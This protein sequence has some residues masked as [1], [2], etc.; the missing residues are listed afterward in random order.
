MIKQFT[1]LI[2]ITF[3]ANAYSYFNNIPVGARATGMAGVFTSIP[4]DVSLVYYNPAGLEFINQKELMTDYS[5]MYSGLTDNSNITNKFIGLNFY[6]AQGFGSAAAGF[7]NTGLDGYVQYS[8]FILSY[9]KKIKRVSIG[10]NTK[11]ISENYSMNNYTSDDPVFSNGTVSS[12]Q[13]YS[14]D[15]SGL[16]NIA[17]RIYAGIMIADITQPVMQFKQYNSV[18]PDIDKVPLGIRAGISFVDSLIT[19]AIDFESVQDS[20]KIYS[21]FEKWF[22]KNKIFAVRAGIGAGNREFFQASTGFSVNTG[23]LQVDYSLIYPLSGISNTAGTNSISFSYKF[24]SLNTANFTPGSIEYNYAVLEQ[25]NQ[26]LQKRN[27]VLTDDNKKLM[28]KL[29]TETMLQI[30]NKLVNSEKNEIIAKEP[31]T[32]PEIKVSTITEI[33]PVETPKKTEKIKEKIFKMLGSTTAVQQEQQKEPEKLIE[34]EK[35]RNI[36]IHT[37]K[38]GETL[39]SIA[40]QYYGEQ[41]KW[42]KIYNQNKN[43]IRKKGGITPGMELII[44]VE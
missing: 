40:E 15:I 31:V 3:S 29:N 18:S 32:Q 14:F 28:N 13:N 6:Q 44:L 5:R 17:P 2:L 20:F 23:Y 25:E 22:F 43:K 42:S 27:N 21:G 24:K 38:S 1:L 34:T 7:I 39:N 11:L 4:G 36:L 41:S 30:K 19:A 35:K 12:L 26:K 37:V 10:L 8:T 16:W 33:K 9:A